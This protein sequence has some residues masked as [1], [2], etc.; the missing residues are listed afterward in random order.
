MVRQACRKIVI[1]ILA[2]KLRKMKGK[3]EFHV[4]SNLE[5]QPD[6]PHLL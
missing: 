5:I 3:K 2:L 1:D 4:S 6:E